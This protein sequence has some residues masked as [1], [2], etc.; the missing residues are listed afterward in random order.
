MPADLSARDTNSNLSPRTETVQDGRL[1]IRV[2]GG[3]AGP[4][5]RRGDRD[6]IPKFPSL[7]AHANETPTFSGRWVHSSFA[8]DRP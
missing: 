6:R 7:L 2:M 8:L 3:T 1:K 4:P 5:R